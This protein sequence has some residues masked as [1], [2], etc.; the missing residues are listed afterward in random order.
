M[1]AQTTMTPLES[2]SLMYEKIAHGNIKSNTLDDICNYANALV[3][4]GH[5]HRFK[6]K[7]GDGIKYCHL[8]E[9]FL[10]LNEDGKT[11]MM[12][13]YAARDASSDGYVDI[14]YDEEFWCYPEVLQ[15][16]LMHPIMVGAVLRSDVIDVK[17]NIS[18]KQCGSGFII[19]KRMLIFDE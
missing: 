15:H 5:A 3:R 10:E 6:F 16:L 12:R 1:T 14:S 8:I 11:Y 13:M 2:Y 7:G 19:R 18:T 9:I 17:V 4:D